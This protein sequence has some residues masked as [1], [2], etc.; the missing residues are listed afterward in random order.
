MPW[1]PPTAILCR[2]ENPLPTPTIE[3]GKTLWQETKA[4]LKTTNNKKYTNAMQKIINI[5]EGVTRMPE[6]RMA[7]PVNFQ[8]EDG[9][10]IAIVGPNGGGKSMFVDIIVGRHPLLMHDPE[11]DFAPSTKPLVSDNIK[12]I[13]FRDTYG[14][15][16]D[17][18]YYLQQRWN[19]QEIDAETPTAKDKLEEAFLMKSVFHGSSLLK[20]EPLSPWCAL[21]F[22]CKNVIL[23]LTDI[24]CI[25]FYLQN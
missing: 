21:D 2:W 5:K 10:H 8:S 25:I 14:G 15:D 3:D 1:V 11:Y 18:T 20:S 12:Y 16:N 22:S 24:M 6:W 13:T 7:K 9:E 4:E 17:R 23:K 19:Q